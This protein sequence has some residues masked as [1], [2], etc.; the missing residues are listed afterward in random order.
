MGAVGAA[1]GA[2]PPGADYVQALDGPVGHPEIIQ[3]EEGEIHEPQVVDLLYSSGL[4]VVDKGSEFVF[5]AGP[6]YPGQALWT[7]PFAVPGA[8]IVDA[9]LGLALEDQVRAPLQAFLGQDGGV[10][11]PGQD[12]VTRFPALPHE[13]VDLQEVVGPKGESDHVRLKGLDNLGFEGVHVPEIVEG[14]Y[15]QPGLPAVLLEPLGH[16]GQPARD[17]GDGV[18]E[19]K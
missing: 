15:V 5:K 4:L 18:G 6:A 16:I 9:R 17:G 1:E 19:Q 12:K 13:P 10:V 7:G 11:A 14:V 3:V 8:E 2:T